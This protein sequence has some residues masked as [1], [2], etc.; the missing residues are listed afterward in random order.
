[1]DKTILAE[2]V[3]I[4]PIANPSDKDKASGVKFSITVK[5]NKTVSLRKKEYT[6]IYHHSVKVKEHSLKVG[7]SIAIEGFQWEMNGQTGFTTPKIKKL[8]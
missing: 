2:V 1:M 5:E 7:D 6:D 3:D 4:Q 8:V